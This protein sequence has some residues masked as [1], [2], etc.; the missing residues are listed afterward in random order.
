MT[1]PGTETPIVP[2]PDAVPMAAPSWLFWIL[3][4]VTFLLHT[5]CMNLALGGSI[6][7]A[8]TRLQVR[9]TLFESKLYIT[10]FKALPVAIA[11][12]I[13][14]GVASLLFVQVLYGRLLY[15]SSILMGWIW[16]AVIPLIIAAYYGTYLVVFRKKLNSRQSVVLS[17]G[18]AILFLTVAFIYGNNMSLMLRPETFLER[19]LVDGRGLWLNL[20]DTTLAPRFAHS[21]VGAIAVA[22]LSTAVYGVRKRTTQSQFG[23]WLVRRGSGLFLIAT[24][25]N[26]IIGTWYLLSFEREVLLEFMKT[27]LL[28]SFALV[29]AI[30]FGFSSL[31]TVL[32]GLQSKRQG[33]FIGGG[34][35]LLIL[36]LASMLVVRDQ[37]RATILSSALTP[38]NWVV[39][40]W[41]AISLFIVLV[42]AAVVTIVW[43]VRRFIDSGSMD[44]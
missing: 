23:Q 8:F 9:K 2:L 40:Q 16:L 6:L 18:I 34:V 41:G 21:I 5:L 29:A 14:F 30:V 39:P 13:T 37:V 35:V 28:G 17:F 12:T 7:A 24:A 33:P 19:Y 32:L 43:M 44:G 38:N 1:V 20:S 27:S 11:A 31:A 4:M 10:T 36:T 3:L 42:V 22:G 15:T 26:F 25:V